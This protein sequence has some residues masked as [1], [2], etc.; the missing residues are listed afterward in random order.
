MNDKLE[1]KECFMQNKEKK[2][3]EIEK[4]LFE[5]LEEDDDLMQEMRKLKV[6][7]D[8]N[9]KITNVIEENS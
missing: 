2:W 1:R 4:I 6:M 7:V 3:I 5:Y 8:P 9:R